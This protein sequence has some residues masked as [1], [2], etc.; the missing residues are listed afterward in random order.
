MSNACDDIR[1]ALAA[2]EVCTETEH[3]S[4]VTTHCLYPSFDPVNVFV[5][6]FGGGFR[7]HDGGGAARS[8][9]THG[10][11]ENLISRML[12]KQAQLYRLKISNDSLTAEVQS[13][14][15]LGS[16]I[17]A[18]A[19][20]SAA[21]AHAA[22]DRMMTATEAVLKDKIL[23]VLKETVPPTTIA[24]DYEVAGQSKRHK[25]DF[26]V[27]EFDGSMLLL[28]AVAPHHISVSSKYVAFSDIIHRDDVRTDR[29]A[30][31]DKGLDAGDVS[32]LLQVAEIVPMQALS[33]GLKRLMLQ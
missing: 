26:A 29:W 1:A 16:A 24:V 21:A 28:N 33:G 2:F 27:T 25:F 13:V 9:W 8:A 3:G 31:H 11:D 7:V 22:V 19:N 5:A 18:V 12:T 20:A 10:R 15:W 32:L 6:R 4:R 14:D 30:V 23:R 17:L